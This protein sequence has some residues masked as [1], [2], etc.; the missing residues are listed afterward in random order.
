MG[1]TENKQPIQAT[2]DARANGDGAAFSSILAE[3]G[4]WTVIGS[5]PV[6][7][8]YTAE[9]D[10]A[11]LQWEGTATAESGKP[12]NSSSCWVGRVAD[13]EVREDMALVAEL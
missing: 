12:Y 3:D 7:Q 5:D 1:A 2:F 10:N 13:G 11:V 6:S 9:G 8:T 4:Q